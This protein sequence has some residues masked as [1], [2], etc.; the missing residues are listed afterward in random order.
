M[1][2]FFILIQRQAVLAP[3]LILLLSI[4]TGLVNGQEQEVSENLP[5]PEQGQ[6]DE[7]LKPE[8]SK[9]LPASDQDDET[10]TETSQNLPI[11]DQSEALEMEDE[12]DRETDFVSNSLKYDIKTSRKEEL[13]AWCRVLN[14]PDDGTVDQLKSR[15]H[16]YYAIKDFENS[17]AVSSESGNQVIIESAKRSE[18]FEVSIAGGE[19]EPVVKLSG[20]VVLTVNEAKRNR[21]HEVKADS[22]LFNEGSNTISAVGNIE[23]IVDTNGREERFTGDSLTFD[24]ND[25]TGIIFHGTSERKEEIDK[26]E[27][28]F[29]FRGDSIKRA[30]ANIMVLYNGSISS[31]DT[32]N[33]DYAL[34]AK[35]IWITGPGEWS[36]FSATIYVGHVPMLYL[37]FYWKSGRDLFFNPVIGQRTDKGYYIQTT[38]YLI[39][40]KEE[41]DGFSM[42]G[43]GD[44]AGGEYELVREGLYLV[45]KPVD[46]DKQ[47]DNATAKKPNKNTLKYTLDAYTGLG[48]ATGLTG[49]FPKLGDNGK[50]NFYLSLGVSRSIDT[51]G[52]VY[53]LDGTT[54][55]IYWNSTQ[56]G[57][58]TLPFR[59]GSL[60][61]FSYKKWKLLLNWYSDP[62]Y[63]QDFGDRQENFDWLRLLLSEEDETEKAD[64]ISTLKWELAGSHSFNL[65]KLSP[66]LS[67]INISHLKMSLSWKN[68]SNASITESTNPDKSVNPARSFYYPNKLILPDLKIVVR[69]AL[70]SYTVKRKKKEITEET[71]SS[72]PDQEK[73]SGDDTLSMN[74]PNIVGDFS[75][76]YNSK[77]F[78]ASLKYD[79]DSRFYME[80]NLL[81]S[82]WDDPSDINFH[83]FSGTKINTIQQGNIHYGLKFWDGLIGFSGST[84][85][86]GHYQVHEPFFGTEATIADT[87]KL[88]DY[89]YTKFN[90]DNILSLKT[91]PLQG[92]PSLSASEVR[93]SID[94][95]ILNYSFKEESTVDD[96]QY[97][98]NWI[99][100]KEDLKKH[101]ATASFKFKRS[102]VSFS[103]DFTSNVP[104]L[105]V[106][107]TVKFATGVDYRGFKVGINQNNT[108][109]NDEW[110]HNP[111]NMT[112]SWKGWKDEV[113]LAQTAQFDVEKDRFSKVDSTLKFWGAKARFVASHTK[114]YDWSTQSNSW[115]EGEEAFVPSLLEFSFNRTF[116]PKPS[117]KNR[118]KIKTIIDTSWKINLIKPTDNV[119]RF[120]W[121]QQLDIHKFLSL[122]ITFSAINRS[123]Y[124]YFPELRDKFGITTGSSNFFEDLLKSFNIFND[125]DRIESQ[126]NMEKISVGMVHHLRNWDLSLEYSGWPKLNKDTKSYDWKSEFSI[127][128][129]WNPLP[130]FN[131]K[132]SLKDDV[133]SVESFGDNIDFE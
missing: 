122:K 63:S 118:I 56:L 102:P 81:D 18:Y 10:E 59:W 47:S 28:P 67:G 23:Y 3:F 21:K 69:G 72:P 26:K 33:P 99:E 41:D 37:P 20:D 73:V 93:Y 64:S 86:S 128:I 114:T 116:A 112:A 54:P 130:L 16:E 31:T 76:I 95:N 34:K 78:E 49:A 70:P 115:V 92:I 133:W 27:V 29:F 68:K 123:M 15:L 38:S 40:Q 62:Y 121:T 46:A 53:F 1:T 94:A 101:E 91:Y 14:L 109:E 55:K 51:D 117:W 88:E 22:I 48:A 61:D 9:V 127:F 119:L 104:P 71:S 57:T 12:S 11:S 100:D 84:K 87:T 80:D 132:T 131:Q 98:L 8:T 77:L 19:K 74:R 30:S 105:D 7:A 24:V 25:W 32:D 113:E 42:L 124:L 96:P 129:K 4:S 82:D 17:D 45:K 6:E 89:K 39:G 111:I 83:D 110:K 2:K 108:F 44:S 13:V 79:L 66:W 58:A 125:K 35:K 97:M 5:V 43:F 126:F 65:K 60:V 85:L 107:Y 52:N 106:K 50:L 90:W 75:G 36:I 103:T 120:R